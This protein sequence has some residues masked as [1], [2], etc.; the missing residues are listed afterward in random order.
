M[1]SR[2]PAFL[3][4]ISLSGCE[5]GCARAWFEEHGVGSEGRKPAG[6]PALNAT[7]C[8]DGLARCSEGVVEVS[9]LAMIP[10]PCRGTA[11]QCSCPWERVT[12]CERGCVVDGLETVAGRSE[13][14]TQLCAAP[15]DAGAF[16]RPL[17]APAGCEDGQLFRCSGGQVVSCAEGAVV[18]ACARGC[19][20]EGAALGD[21]L[22]V[23][24]EAAFAI[25]CSR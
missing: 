6:S 8:P 2:L 16:A 22:P 12:E 13:A 17:H 9:R 21:E 3:L 10:A 18:G 14:V 5:R 20:A 11:E 7:D 23:S 25:L 19:F 1:P 15:P 4:I 24:R